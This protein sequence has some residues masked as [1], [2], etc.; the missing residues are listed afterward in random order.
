M[1]LEVKSVPSDLEFELLDLKNLCS[2]VSLGGNSIGY[3]DRLTD[4]LNRRPTG[5]YTRNVPK[6]AQRLI[7]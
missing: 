1:A 4:R 6:Y 3:L 2:P 5:F 7:G